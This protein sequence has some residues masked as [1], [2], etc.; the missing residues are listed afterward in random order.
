MAITNRQD[1]KDY[2]L[3]NKYSKW[4]FCI[5][6]KDLLRNWSKKSAQQ[7][8]EGHHIIPKSITPNNDIVYLTPKEHFICHLLLPKMLCDEEY[9]YKMQKALWNISHTR[10]IKINSNLY[11]SLRQD[12][13]KKCSKF[14]TGENNP[15]FG[16]KQSENFFTTKCKKY[17]F[18]FEENRVEITNLRKFCR[19]NNLDQGAMTR[20]NSGKQITHKG[21]SLWQQ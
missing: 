17:T 8:V 5:V 3:E 19:E 13:S 18:L 12:Y 4:Y 9:V 16:K 6:E 11:L 15:M 21:Y 10:N 2:C 20:V 14:M 1:F 7:Y